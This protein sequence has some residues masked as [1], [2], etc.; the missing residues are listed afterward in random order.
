MKKALSL[1]LLS[2]ILSVSVAQAGCANGMCGIKSKPATKF[3]C[4]NGK[5]SKP[6]NK[7]KYKNFANTVYANQSNCANGQCR[8][9]ASKPAVKRGGCANGRCGR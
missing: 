9:P 7:V 1:I 5:C 8:R 3:N 6:A 2:S 4:S